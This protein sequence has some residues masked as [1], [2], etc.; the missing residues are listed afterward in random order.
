[1]H[2]T[3]VGLIA[4]IIVLLSHTIVWSQSAPATI[5]YYNKKCGPLSGKTPDQMDPSDRAA[6]EDMAARANKALGLPGPGFAVSEEYARR[7]AI[8]RLK[9]AADECGA[10]NA[11]RER[12]GLPPIHPVDVQIE[13]RRRAVREYCT[14]R[15]LPD[16]CKEAARIP[17]RTR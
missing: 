7:A 16:N 3:I 5:L 10:D 1:M 2:Q 14:S 4:S 8:E 11:C 15:G 6:C 9:K 12:I 17:G 13:R